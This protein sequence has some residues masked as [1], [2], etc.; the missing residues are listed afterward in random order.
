MLCAP[1]DA[2]MVSFLSAVSSPCLRWRRQW[3]GSC[4]RGRRPAARVGGFHPQRVRMQSP[5]AAPEDRLSTRGRRI[6]IVARI[7]TPFPPL[8]EQFLCR[9]RVG[10]ACRSTTRLRWKCCGDL[11]ERCGRRGAY[12]APERRVNVSRKWH[13]SDNR[14]WQ[15]SG[16][17][18]GVVPATMWFARF[19]ANAGSV[20]TGVRLEPRGEACRGVMRRLRG[21]RPRRAGWRAANRS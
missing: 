5:R 21:C 1:H 15:A 2:G 17:V 19:E 8:A 9:L 18:D 3:E 4:R 10:I 13:V 11:A 12:W 7:E 20:A 6:F 16:P 14:K